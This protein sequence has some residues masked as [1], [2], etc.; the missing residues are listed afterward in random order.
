MLKK[1]LLVFLTVVLALACFSATACNKPTVYTITF[2][3]DGGSIVSEQKIEEGK[4]ISKPAD[5]T[6]E[7][8]TF[9]NWY[10]DGKTSP[11]DF[12]N[13]TVDK[14]MTI[15]AKWTVNQYSISFDTNGGEPSNI[16]KITADYDTIV[17]A[18]NSPTKTGNNFMGWYEEG[19]ETPYV[20]DKI[21]ARDVELKAKWEIGVY[22]ITFDSNGG[23]AVDTISNKYG[24]KVEK[25]SDPTKTGYT[26]AGWFESS[27]LFAYTFNTIEARDVELKARWIINQYT[28]TFNTDGGDNNVEDITKD[29]GTT[30]TMPT[31]PTKT[32]YSFAGWFEE[33]SSVAYVFSTIE[34]RN[35]SLK[36]KWTI[37][38]YSISFDSNGGT[39]VATITKDFGTSVVEPTAPTKPGSNFLGWF[40][41]GSSIAY[42]FSTIEARNVLLK[43][44]WGDAEEHSIIFDSDGGSS[45]DTIIKRTGLSISAPTNP[46]KTG[47]SF[48]G[49]FE[50][51]SNVAYVFSTMENRNIVLKAKWTINQYSITF[52]SNGGSAV[53]N[54]TEDYGA[55]VVAPSDPTRSG[56]VFLGWF[57]EGQT[58]PYEFNKIEARN[59]TLKAKWG[60][61][62]GTITLEKNLEGQLV[63]GFTQ[64]SI[65]PYVGQEVVLPELESVYG[66]IFLGWKNLK[67]DQML[68]KEDG[69]YKIIHDGQDVT[70]QAQW[71]KTSLDSDIV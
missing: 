37:N 7:G 26:F 47:Y 51:G 36:A 56:Y 49:W 15:K 63:I 14:D 43:A 30:V 41:E 68:E 45:V 42:V 60:E 55:E 53:N 3:T 38:Q 59:I 32:G 4:K 21:E 6:K 12:D 54:I 44:K 62:R 28:I 27:S 67:T 35:V 50:E 64:S 11:F 23:T 1:F 2:D 33:G 39:I 34:A 66:Y 25:P 70:Y 17:S 13:T 61:L 40:E 10:C 71:Q 52:N 20:F 65:S 48:A 46:T 31:N 9:E 57:E 58:T 29:Y 19:K 8:H 16:D 22:K 18:P 69:E 24:E 5:P